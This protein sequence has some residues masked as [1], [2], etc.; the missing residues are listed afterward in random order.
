ML[1][2]FILLSALLQSPAPPDEIADALGHAEVLYEAAHFEEAMTLLTRI[3]TV[4]KGLPGRLKD[5]LQ[6]KLQL[7]LNSIGMNETAKAKAFFMALYALDPD[8]ALDGER[9]SSKVI[10]VA[11]DAKTEQSKVWCFD[12]QTNARK[13]LDDGQMT[14]FL[15][16]MESSGEKCVVLGAM[17]PEAAEIFY[18]SGL[19]SY[20]RGEFSDALSSFE[21][22]LT[23]SP[24]HEMARQYA[25]LAHEQLQLAA[26]IRALTEKLP[27]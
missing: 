22:A 11:A 23:L 2:I 14:A 4:L 21:T 8:Y 19:A 15:H 12:A 9:F 16:L 3:D 5:K 25:D 6:T 1:R 17:A 13:Y 18:R 7:A 10:A 27:Q 26:E 24:E 20:K